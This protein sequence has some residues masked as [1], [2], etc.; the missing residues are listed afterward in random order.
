MQQEEEIVRTVLAMWRDGLEPTKESWRQHASAD[1]VWWNSA[2]G[3]ISGIAACLAGI[4]QLFGALGAAYVDVPIRNVL[5]EPGRVIVERSDNL[6][7]ADGTVI[8]YAPV[9]GVIEF[10]GDKIVMWRDYCDDWI[11]KMM[12][13]GELSPATAP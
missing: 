5:A 6:H 8:A 13:G 1:I 11:G 12:A 7:R 3:G 4:D 10:D 2:R 9:T